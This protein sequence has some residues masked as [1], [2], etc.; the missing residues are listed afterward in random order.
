[1]MKFAI[2]A[3]EMI[4][5]QLLIIRNNHSL[6]PMIDISHILPSAA[7]H[8]KGW[9]YNV[10]RVIIQRKSAGFPLIISCDHL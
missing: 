8:S 10:W 4:G 6:S 1:M 7:L 3:A 9:D 2:Q 5:K